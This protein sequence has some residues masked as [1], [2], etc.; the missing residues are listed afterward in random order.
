[1]GAVYGWPADR[2]HSQ[3]QTS[4]RSPT[5][6]RRA[7]AH[8]AED[9]RPPRNRQAEP[10][11]RRRAR[12]SPIA[13][14]GTLPSTPSTVSPCVRRRVAGPSDLEGADQRRQLIRDIQHFLP[15]SPPRP[16]GHVR[17]RLSREKRVELD[18]ESRIVN[19]EIGAGAH[20]SF[21]RLRFEQIEIVGR[22]QGRCVRRVPDIQ[23]HAAARRHERAG[24]DVGRATTIGRDH[25]RRRHCR[26]NACRPW[27][28][29]S[30]ESPR[31]ARTTGTTIERDNTVRPRIKTRD[32]RAAPVANAHKRERRTP[33]AA[34]S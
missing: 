13:A 7:A 5:G 8:A 23:G 1:M 28:G 19:V 6:S 31:Q 10:A 34:W 15:N 24:Q 2:S 18:C 16:L 32:R 11:T 12:R 27:R 26:R 3:S 20:E 17:D 22:Q 4:R 9:T 14:R 25:D 29:A 30:A 33:S 21:V